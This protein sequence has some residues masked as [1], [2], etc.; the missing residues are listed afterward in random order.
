[1]G[2]SYTGSVTSEPLQ[3]VVPLVGPRDEVTPVEAPVVLRHRRTHV[4]ADARHETVQE[5]VTALPRPPAAR[6]PRGRPAVV[7]Q[8]DK[9]LPLSP[10]LV[11][12]GRLRRRRLPDPLS[13]PDHDPNP[14]LASSGY[15]GDPRTFFLHTSWGFE[16]AKVSQVPGHR[17]VSRY[18]T[19]FSVD[20]KSGRCAAERPH[21]RVVT[22]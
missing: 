5:V 6:A 16:T 7:E 22:V 21:V 2:G 10:P 17:L 3:S 8:P 12:V 14:L 1:M 4:R 15:L 11:L 19:D 13:D 9:P 20:N 18:G